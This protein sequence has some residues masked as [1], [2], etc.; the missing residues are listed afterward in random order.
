MIA[1]MRNPILGA[2]FLGYYGL[3]VDIRCR[4]LWEIGT[5]LSVQGVISSSP[6]PSPWLLPKKPSND[7]TAIMTEFSNITQP[8]SKSRPIKHNITH[9]INMTGPPVSVHPRRLAHGT[10]KIAGQE[11]EHMLELGII[12]SLSSS[13]SS[14]FH[15]VVKKSAD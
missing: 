1:N 15:M 2:D 6:S 10:L 11:F 9:H 5:Q 4:R 3:I 14:P 12:R 13:W 7:F 8:C